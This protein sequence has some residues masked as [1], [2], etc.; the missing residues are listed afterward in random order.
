MTLRSLV[1]GLGQIGME[2]DLKLDPDAYVMTHARAFQ[3]HSDFQLVGGVDSNSDRCKIFKKHYKCPA[4]TELKIALQETR[5]DIVAIAL[6]TKLHS[7]TLHTILEIT[8]PT[9]ILCEKPLSYDLVEAKKMVELCIKR[10][11]QL[12][13][14]FI[15]RSDPGIMEL[16]YRL[17][18]KLIAGPLKG[19]VWYSKGLF[20]N[21]SHLFNLL[22]FLLG[23]M[24]ELKLINCGRLWDNHDPEPDIQ[25]T[26]RH[27][28]VVFLAAK[29]EKFSYATVELLADNGR[30][31][32]ENGGEIITWQPAIEDPV[33]EGY[34]ILSQ[35]SEHIQSDLPR[36][37]W[38]VVEQLS[39]SMKGMTAQICTGVEALKTLESLEELRE[40]L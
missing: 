24:L 9:V 12:Y 37:Q 20:H 26:Y 13:V 1:V 3:Q 33:I 7:E 31:R 28:T 25:V 23:D 34:T 14:N 30:V 10:N 40:K 16:K 38:N 39:R 36:H 18:K 8:N 32:M 19:V 15:R 29:E 22:Q 27:G 11:C 35:D 21:G 17:E 4:Y 2:Y 6:P 5:P